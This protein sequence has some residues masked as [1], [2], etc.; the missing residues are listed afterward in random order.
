MFHNHQYP[1]WNDQPHERPILSTQNPFW[2]ADWA[3]LII[4][5][6]VFVIAFLVH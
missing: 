4:P 1:N 2:P 5:V 3:W 6:I